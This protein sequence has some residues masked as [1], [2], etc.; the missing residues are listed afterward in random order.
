MPSREF[1]NTS[2]EDVLSW[3][4]NIDQYNIRTTKR[5]K[6]PETFLREL[7]SGLVFQQ[8]ILT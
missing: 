7:L 3:Y 8:K 5:L 1:L 6:C 4:G 2:P